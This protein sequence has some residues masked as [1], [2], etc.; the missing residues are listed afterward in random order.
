MNPEIRHDRAR[1]R[2]EAIVDGHLCT[3]DYQLRGDVLWMM[4]TGVP[5]TVGGRGVAAR[6]VQAAL[7]W[8]EGQG[9]RIE[10]ACSYVAAYMRRHP[11]TLKLLA[12]DR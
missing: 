4:H 10:P 7:D 9:W 6:L 3:A 12:R 8:A 11:Q 5:E 2:F 1:N